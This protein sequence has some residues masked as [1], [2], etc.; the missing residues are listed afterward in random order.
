IRGRAAVPGLDIVWLLQ[1]AAF[2]ETIG[3]NLIEDRVLDPLRRHNLGHRS[4][5]SS[6][7]L[8]E[9]LYSADNERP[10]TDRWTRVGRRWSVVSL[11]PFSAPLVRPS[12]R[13]RWA[14]KN[15]IMIGIEPRTAAAQN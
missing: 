10:T 4:L 1:P 2:R 15:T 5:L 11:Y 3:E 7:R 6:E 9:K 13:K 12:T 8:S 14:R